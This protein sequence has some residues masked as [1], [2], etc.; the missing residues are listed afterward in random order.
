MIDCDVHHNFT[1]IKELSPWLE[2]TWRQYL[3]RGG[4]SGYSL[5]N[6][7]WVHPS[8]FL[9]GDA[10]PPNGGIAGSDYDTMRSQLLDRWNAEYVVLNGEDILN[11]SCIPNHHFGRALAQAYNR[12]TL[13]TWLPQ[14]DRLRA[15]M[16]VDVEDPDGA[17]ADIREFAQHPGVVQVLL[18]TGARR[19][20]GDPFYHAVFEAAAE[21][22]LPVAMHAGADGL[23]T[24]PPPTG[25]GYPRFYIEYHTLI[26]SGAMAHLVSLLCSGLFERVPDLRL[27]VVETGVAWLPGVLWRLDA[28]WKALRAEVPWV[29][30]LPSETVQRQVRFTTQ[31]LEQPANGANLRKLLSAVDGMEN[32]LMFATDYPHWDV[33]VAELV[34]RRLPPEWSSK[35]M[36]ENARSFYGL[37]VR[38]TEKAPA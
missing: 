20:Y 4:Y 1:S 32:M 28:N 22:G 9:M 14:D 2:P 38:D 10:A 25:A 11:V 18:P 8:G 34:E 16:V 29:K 27:A 7:P 17:V 19:A 12:W 37:P 13:E 21:A 24:N 36:G 35:V 23:G 31:P 5:P 6:Y 30:T 15:S 3:D 26:C 33:D